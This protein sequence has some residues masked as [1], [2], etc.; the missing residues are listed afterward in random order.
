MAHVDRPQ[1]EADDNSVVADRDS[2]R[3]LCRY[4]VGKEHASANANRE[5]DSGSGI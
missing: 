1:Y 2:S 3:D 4:G 5:V